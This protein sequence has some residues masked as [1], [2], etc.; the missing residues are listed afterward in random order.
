MQHDSV[1][2]VSGGL[3]SVTMVYDMIT[4]GR[5]PH[6]LSFNYGQRHKKELTYAG[7]VAKY[8]SLKWDVVDLQG[9]TH[10]IS[11]SALTNGPNAY[12]GGEKVEG[13]TIDVP[14]GHYAADNMAATVVPNR[15][16]IM[17][18]IAAGVAVNFQYEVVATGV[19]A[20]DHD[21]YPDCRPEFIDA[22]A[23]TIGLATEGFGN[24]LTDPNVE[25][26]IT[27]LAPYI[28]WSKADIAR[29]AFEVGVPLHNTWSCYKGD[30][31]H[32]GRCGTCVE[33]LEAID[34]AKKQM[35]MKYPNTETVW[36]DNTVYND[37]EFWKGE[38]AK[39]KTR[40]HMPLEDNAL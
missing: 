26:Q 33:R 28:T 16:M 15:N 17:L 29:R 21:V 30:A 22:V 5:T 14:E 36:V 2:I 27:V 23:Q 10:L 37:S 6:L 13:I 20:G 7:M 9:L 35:L 1:A 19:H 25:G 3:D 34:T 38:I 4:R 18:A 11:N 40:Q 8:F 12:K 32:C 39:S 24:W 31:V